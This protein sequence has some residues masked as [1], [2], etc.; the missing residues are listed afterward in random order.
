MKTDKI[1]KLEEVKPLIYIILGIDIN[2]NDCVIAVCQTYQ[3]A[4]RYCIQFLMESSYYDVWV[5]KHWLL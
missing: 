3:E 5:E 2:Q 4:K 1:V